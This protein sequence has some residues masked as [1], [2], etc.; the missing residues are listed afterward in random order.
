M[1]EWKNE[2]HSRDTNQQGNQKD[3]FNNTHFLLKKIKVYIQR[4]KEKGTLEKKGHFS[5]LE[6]AKI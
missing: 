2:L 4:N 5:L 6:L 1:N 3:I